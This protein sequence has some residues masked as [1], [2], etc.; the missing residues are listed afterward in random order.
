MQLLLS[1]VIQTVPTLET[2][3][4]VDWHTEDNPLAVEQEESQRETRHRRTGSKA[5]EESHSD[6]F[7]KPDNPENEVSA[8]ADQGPKSGSKSSSES[9]KQGR[10]KSPKGPERSR[11]K[12]AASR[13]GKGGRP[14][15][16][17]GRRRPSCCQAPS[18]PPGPVGLPGMQGIQGIQG[19]QGTQGTQGPPGPYGMSG[20]KGDKGKIC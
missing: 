3:E 12:G 18:G 14:V 17:C 2:Y 9:T 11:A 10:P 1:T 20:P 16:H 13:L 19:V 5:R 15:G 7:L 8:K 4:R 6:G